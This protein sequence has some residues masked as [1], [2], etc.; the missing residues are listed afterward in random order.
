MV[1]VNS[2]CLVLLYYSIFSGFWCIQRWSMWLVFFRYRSVSTVVHLYSSLAQVTCINNFTKW[3]TWRNPNSG[4][5]IFHAKIQI[6][7]INFFSR[8]MR[9]ISYCKYRSY[10]AIL[11]VSF[12]TYLD[13]S[14][15]LLSLGL[16]QYILFQIGL[17]PPNT[18]S[19]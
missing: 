16:S 4:K 13:A 14:P 5:R 1:R 11:S 9:Q 7:N 15:I 19:K 8:F 10:Y 2:T 18:V 6:V 3:I 12:S 17:I